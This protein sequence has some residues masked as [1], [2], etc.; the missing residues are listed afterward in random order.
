MW[1][2][3]P[4]PRPSLCTYTLTYTYTVTEPYAQ[5]SGI[6]TNGA[7]GSCS[8]WWEGTSAAYDA[9]AK[10]P[11]T[12][13]MVMAP[14]AGTLAPSERVGFSFVL[15][16]MENAGMASMVGNSGAMTACSLITK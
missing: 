5:V 16:F 6:F 10:Y 2:A 3:K 14:A 7:K 12:N 1:P 15:P 9:L 11:P 4:K 8:F 13:V